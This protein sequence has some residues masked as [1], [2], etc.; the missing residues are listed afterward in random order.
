MEKAAVIISIKFHSLLKFLQV[1][2]AERERQRVREEGK[3]AIA[4]LSSVLT[5][6][7]DFKCVFVRGCMCTFV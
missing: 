2:E 5:L 1:Y 3:Q 4:L 6:N 7:W